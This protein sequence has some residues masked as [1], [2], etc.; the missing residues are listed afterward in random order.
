MV[1]QVSSRIG[2]S[3]FRIERLLCFVFL[4]I[5]VTLTDEL[6]RL[7]YDRIKLSDRLH[8]LTTF[9]VRHDK[10]SKIRQFYV[11]YTDTTTTITNLIEIQVKC[12]ELLI[13]RIR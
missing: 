12:Q 10:E 9:N 6:V 1:S 13:R 3:I 11:E 2:H 5:V 8:T 7:V 4:G